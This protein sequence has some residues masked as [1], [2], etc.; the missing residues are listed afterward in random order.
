M[1][2]ENR[3]QDRKREPPNPKQ[4][5]LLMGVVALVAP[6]Q[7]IYYPSFRFPEV[8]IFAVM[9]TLLVSTTGWYILIPNY[10]NLPLSMLYRLIIIIGYLIGIRILFA[11]QTMRYFQ[12][13]TT[14]KR[15]IILGVLAELPLAVT[16]L[17]NILE[18]IILTAMYEGGQF[19]LYLF[20]PIP[21]PSML[22]LVLLLLR[23]FPTPSESDWDLERETEKRWVET[24]SDSTKTQEDKLT[25]ANS[26]PTTVTLDGGDK[27]A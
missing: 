8:N 19:T 21:V 20:S 18:F 10:L 6:Y 1:N 2:K 7:F 17:M 14:R 13:K 24:G 25:Q 16:L 26:S 3:E 11:Y 4:V 9:W 12:G 22:P 5:G 23:Y 27:F 15:L